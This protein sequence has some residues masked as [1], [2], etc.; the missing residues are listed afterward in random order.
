MSDA[1]LVGAA[2]AGIAL[3]LFLIVRVK[4]HAFVALLIGSLVIGVAAGMPFE[5]VLDAITTG[6]GSTLAAIA[7]LVGLGAMFGQMLEVSGGAE[8]LAD[9][10]LNRFGERN[11]QW[12]LLAVGFVIA[13][14]VFFDVAFII[15]ISLVYGLTERT[16]RPIVSYALPLLAGLAVTHAFI[17]PTP[18]PIAV[19]GLLGADLGWVMLLGVV[20]G[21]PAAV[22]AGPVY[23]QLIAKRVPAMVPEY[24]HAAK[25]KQA[26]KPPRVSLV[27][28]LIGI[29]LVLIIGNSVASTM[30][31]DD[32][33]LRIGLGFVG[34]PMM[35]LLITTL[36]CF[37]LLGTRAGYSPQEV[38][39]IATKALEPAGIIILVTSAGGVLKQVL[40]DSGVGD[41]FADALMATNLP[42]LILAFLTA[43]AVRL[44]QGSA[45]VAMLTA[46][47][48]VAALLGD[49]GF[50][51]PMLAL[52]VLAIAAGA[53]IASHVNDSGFWLVNRY[54]GLTVPD[55]LKTW[56]VTTC[57]IAFVSITLI[58]I[59]SSFVG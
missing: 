17:P 19:A 1:Q 51:E 2:L 35:A 8:A 39:E 21:L 23:A 45:T 5:E 50:S 46:A 37:W 55:T 57:I 54:L 6:V 31:A 22:I 48:L 28:A 59:A 38:Q 34:H 14:P 16:H 33:A 27:V 40:I 47:G 44:M 56:T 13:I 53:T 9:A 42:P 58:L 24:M 7:V 41:V 11:A 30:L 49:V 32:H 20:V 43:A 36:L 26:R 18:G 12:S 3:L 10:L 15:L 4:L 29:P 25:P 52:L